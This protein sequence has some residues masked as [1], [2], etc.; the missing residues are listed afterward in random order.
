[1]TVLVLQ[2]LIPKVGDT[3]GRYH[4]REQVGKGGFGVVFRATQAGLDEDVAVKVL[5]PHV[6]AK[7]EICQ[8]FEREVRVAKGLRHPNSTRVLDAGQTEAGLPFY[9]MEYLECRSLAQVLRAEG[10]FTAERTRRIALQVL[11]SLGEAHSR[12]V[13]H[14]DLKPSNIMLCDI[15]GED[16]FVK[17]LDFG[18]AKALVLSD[19]DDSETQ[20]GQVLGTP[21][22]M[23]PEQARGQAI[24]PRSDLY[25]VGLLL[26]ECVGGVP[27]VQGESS[28][29]I[30]FQHTSPAP[31]IL[32]PVVTKNPLAEVIRKAIRKQV[33][34][35]YLNADEMRAALVQL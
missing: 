25:S 29:E 18:I 27:L 4:L 14:R 1:M 7:P 32:P 3:I 22:Y 8:R 33:D 21:R 16:D 19:E 17:V 15:Y 5:R 6:V 23:S 31:L 20:T 34:S 9:V 35:R 24:D 11:K 26:A 28:V 10:A 30:M 2:K 13:I 12:G